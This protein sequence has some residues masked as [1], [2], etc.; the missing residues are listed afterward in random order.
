MRQVIAEHAAGVE[1]MTLNDHRGLADWVLP[2][3]GLDHPQ[4]IQAT[5]LHQRAQRGGVFLTHAVSAPAHRYKAL[6]GLGEFGRQL[7]RH[8]FDPARLQRLAELLRQILRRP[9]LLRLHPLG[10]IAEHRHADMAV[11][12]LG[13]D[14]VDQA[15]AI[16]HDPAGRH[17]LVVAQA[18]SAS[19]LR[20]RRPRARKCMASGTRVAR[21]E[22]SGGRARDRSTR[23]TE[24]RSIRQAAGPRAAP[25]STARSV[26]GLTL[27]K[28]RAPHQQRRLTAHKAWRNDANAEAG[29]PRATRG[30]Q[31]AGHRQPQSA[32]GRGDATRPGLAPAVSKPPI[33]PV[34]SRGNRELPIPATASPRDMHGPMRDAS[35][36]LR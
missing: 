12:E 34:A 2:R 6:L 10:L 31:Q 4:H 16:R 14:E 20:T 29:G 25:R 35:A 17:R 13:M 21:S 3:R 27:V 24:C 15:D 30:L 22:D 19:R 26:R 8:Q 9:Q 5:R 33:P 18:A 7:H 32:A 36:I 23:R 1:A 11:R 28:K